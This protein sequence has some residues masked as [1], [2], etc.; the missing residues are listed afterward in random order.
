MSREAKSHVLTKGLIE[1]LDQLVTVYRH[2]LDMV[3]KEQTVL[4]ET[5]LEDLAEVNKSKE[6]MVLKIKQL[7][8]SWTLSAQKLG[9]ALGLTTERPS[10]KELSKSVG[11]ENGE[12]LLNLHSV[13][14]LLVRRI[15]EINKKNETLAQS[16]LSHINGAMRA[17]SETLKENPTYK[18]GGD[19]RGDSDG[20]SGRLIAKEV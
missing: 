1:S 16:A 17:I 10:L 5:R 7:E 13:L 6:Q 20:S 4:M 11:P 9:M 12:K 18:S 8:S 3:R 19:M 15:V 2:L 14:S